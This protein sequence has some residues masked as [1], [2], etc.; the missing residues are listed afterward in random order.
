M[1]PH[2]LASAWIAGLVAALVLSSARAQESTADG[3]EALRTLFELDLAH[4]AVEAFAPRV[5]PGGALAADAE[6]RA[7]VARAHARIGDED[8]ARALLDAAPDL[9]EAA[10]VVIAR[11]W[12]AMRRDA[13]DE[14]LRHLLVEGEG[15]AGGPARLVP[16]FPDEPDALILLAR[17][18]AR[19]GDPFSAEGPAARLLERARLHPEAH[20]ALHVLGTA[21]LERGDGEAAAEL[22]RRR[23]AALQW[24]E[25][26]KVR[27]LQVRRTPDE[28]LPHLGLALV[29]MEVE[30]WPRAE[31]RL[32]TLLARWP[33]EARAWFHLGECRRNRGDT[34]E[35][36]SAYERALALDPAHAPARANRALLWIQVDRTAE[37]QAELEALIATPVGEDVRYAG[38]HLALARLLLESEGAEAAAARYAVYTALG[39]REPLEPTPSEGGD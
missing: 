33:E 35:A 38:L 34:G 22:F 6:A 15:A 25:L 36:L 16:R 4:E 23:D 21:A 29:W 32:T 9:G 26:L 20:T 24:Q 17:V 13:L 10:P 14:A 27:R 1:S 3:L 39:G 8:A 5:A 28:P 19:R 2:R 11:A 37:A 31:A 30:E 7:L 12:L 18:F